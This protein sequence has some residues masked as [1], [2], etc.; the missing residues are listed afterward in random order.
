MNRCVLFIL[1]VLLS[2]VATVSADDREAFRKIYEKE[3]AF[4]M[5]EFP[6]FASNAGI[7]DYAD[8]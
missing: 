5:Q 3:W 2:P 8:N 7:D 4:R 6:M 1:A